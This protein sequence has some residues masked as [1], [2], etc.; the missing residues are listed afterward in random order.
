[1]RDYPFP[2]KKSAGSITRLEDHD[3]DGRYESRTLFL[4][5]LAWPTGSFPT[6]MESSSRP[7]RTSSS[8]RIPTVTASPMSGR[9]MFTGFGTENV[10][11]LVNGLLWGLD[12]WI[13]GVTSS[14]GG[15]IRNLSRPGAEAGLGPRPRLSFQARWL[16]VRGDLRGRPV[17]PLIRR[18]GTS[19]Y[20][21]QQQSCPADRAAVRDLE[22]NPALIPPPVI[23]DIAAEGPACRCFGSVRPSR[24][25]SSGHVSG[26]RIRSWPGGC[27]PPSCSLPASSPPRPGPPFTGLGLPGGISAGTFSS[28][29][30]AATWSIGSG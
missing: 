3:G 21:Q 1:M 12:G 28:E 18:L 22:R 16:R 30:L 15:L 26:P 10:Q 20:L 14:N 24:G 11:G 19:L 29:T 4:D 23:L 7:R 27:R 5:G 6:T 2:G 9:S 13:Y 8:P 17:R 25:V